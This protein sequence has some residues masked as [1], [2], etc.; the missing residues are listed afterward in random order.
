[1]GSLDRHRWEDPVK[2]SAL[3]LDYDG[4]I[5]V[6]GV[7]DPGVREAIAEAR[8]KGIAVVLVTGRRLAELRHVAGDLARVGVG[9]GASSSA[10]TR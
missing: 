10:R 7:L 6:D 5:A 4:T 1:M 2:L 3:A 9:S 8:Q